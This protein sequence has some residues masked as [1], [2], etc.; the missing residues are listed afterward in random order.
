MTH[1]AALHNRAGLRTY[2]DN[3]RLLFALEIRF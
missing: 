1:E 3:A 2:G